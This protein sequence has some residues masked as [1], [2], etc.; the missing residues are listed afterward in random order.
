MKITVSKNNLVRELQRAHGIVGTS[1]PSLILSNLLVEAADGEV[2][3]TATDFEIGLRSRVEAS[4]S[5]PGR[6]TLPAKKTL[7]IARL[8]PETDIVIEQD[9]GH[10]NVSADGFEARMPTAP[11]EE[12]PALPQRPAGASSESFPADVLRQM[13]ERTVFAVARDGDHRYALSGA[14]LQVAPKEMRLVATDGH[15][16]ALASVPVDGLFGDPFEVVIPRKTLAEL[17]LVLSDEAGPVLLTRAENHL[18]VEVGHALVVS[19]LIDGQ[20]PAYESVVPKAYP[21]RVV[22]ARDELLGAVRRVAVLSSSVRRVSARSSEKIRTVK[23]EVS[24]GWVDVSA[25]SPEDGEA[26][27]SIEV[28]YDG[29]RCVVVLNAAYLI[30]FLGAVGTDRVSLS[31]GRGQE[32]LLWAPEHEESRP[33]R[34]VVMP[35]RA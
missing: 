34:Y 25:E 13:I 21:H 11:A 17:R 1:L 28:D 7:D 35:M 2:H 18:F 20:F 19:R 16:L 27:E 24:S 22:F 23:V 14:L 15:R 31:F 10:A 12:F 6:L 4:V 29:P 9:G 8:L 30:D 33:Y 26:K 32:P 5:Q 3:I